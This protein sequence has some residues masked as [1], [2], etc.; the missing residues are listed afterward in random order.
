MHLRTPLC[1]LDPRG[2]IWSKGSPPPLPSIV[3]V[4]ISTWGWG[5]TSSFKKRNK[6]INQNKKG[7]RA[8]Q[9]FELLL[10]SVFHSSHSFLLFFSCR[11]LLC[12]EVYLQPSPPTPI[13]DLPEM[14][15]SGGLHKEIYRARSKSCVSCQLR[16]FTAKMASDSDCGLTQSSQSKN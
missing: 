10:I 8:S 14:S 5:A 7:Q 13:L 16:Q 3:G 2:C 15:R 12:N 11:K 1:I 9:I 6:Q 4:H